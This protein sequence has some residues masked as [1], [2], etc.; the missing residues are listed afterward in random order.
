MG[1][2]TLAEVFTDSQLHQYIRE[3][4]SLQHITP[5]VVWLMTNGFFLY[6]RLSVWQS[7]STAV[8]WRKYR[9]QRWEKEVNVVFPTNA[10]LAAPR[11]IVMF[12]VKMALDGRNCITGHCF[13][14]KPDYL[15]INPNSP[16]FTVW[17]LLWRRPREFWGKTSVV[18]FCMTNHSV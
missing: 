14:N 9:I 12:H 5:L 13:M 6:T 15:S 10:P 4:I 8:W 17:W 1:K 11:S 16:R 7:Q 18:S 2:P 3:V